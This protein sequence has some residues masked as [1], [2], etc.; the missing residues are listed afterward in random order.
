[1]AFRQGVWNPVIAI[2]NFFGY[3]MMVFGANTVPLMN[4]INESHLLWGQS[5][6]YNLVALIPR[7]LWPDKPVAIDYFYKDLVGYDFAG[8][9]I[10][11]TMPNDFYLNFGTYFF[12]AYIIWVLIIHLL[13][14]T[15]IRLKAS[16]HTKII[17]L[18]ILT[19]HSSFGPMIEY[20]LLVLVFLLITYI[21]NKRW[22][23]Y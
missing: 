18:S 6:Y 1:M 2:D 9:G 22:N 11:T 4:N 10:F 15:T 19:M 21:V 20:V 14:R 5:Y 17:V 3:Q 13:Y 7:F 12:I 8:G 23:V 16:A